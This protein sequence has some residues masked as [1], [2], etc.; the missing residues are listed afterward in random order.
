MN[1]EIK[2]LSIILILFLVIDVPMITKI[3]YEMYNKQFLRINNDKKVKTVY[4][5]AIIAYFCLVIGLYYFVIKQN[6]N[7]SS[8]EI[9]MQGALF[10]FVVYGIYNGTNK[11][12]IAEFGMEEAIKDTLWGTFVSATISICASYII[13]KYI[14]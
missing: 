6:L 12:T 8:S 14:L 2:S 1:Q 10:G 11:A 4:F 5:G 3:N 7:K 13:K 9:S